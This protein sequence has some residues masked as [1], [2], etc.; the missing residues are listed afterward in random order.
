MSLLKSFDPARLCGKW[1]NQLG[2]HMILTADKCGNISGRY[3]SAVGKAE[4]FYV[5]T[6]RFDTTPPDNKGVSLGWVV[7]YKNTK[8]EAHST[9]TW[10]GLYFDQTRGA[11]REMILTHWLLTRSTEGK[12]VWESTRAGN[13][14][15]TRDEPGDDGVDSN[16]KPGFARPVRSRL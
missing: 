16:A 2:S 1:V 5:L 15:F 14:V 6:G 10:S 9:G 3:N 7:T 11:S 13:D 12:D 8:L 4:D